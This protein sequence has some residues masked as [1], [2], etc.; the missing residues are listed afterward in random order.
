[1]QKHRLPEEVVTSTKSLW[2]AGLGAA[3]LIAAGYAAWSQFAPQNDPL[4]AYRKKFAAKYRKLT[5]RADQP[6]EAIAYFVN[7]RTGGWVRN[8][9]GR[10]ADR[11]AMAMPL[12][13]SQ[14]L[15]ARQ[16]IRQMNRYSSGTGALL[17]PEANAPA[18]GTLGSWSPL[19]PNNQGG[20]TRKLLIHPTSPNIMYAAAVGGGVWKTTDSGANWLP[21]TD[22]AIPNIAVVSLAF[23]PNNPNKIYAG[24][25]EGYFNADAIRGAGIF[26]TTDAGASWNQLSSTT[27]SDFWYVNDIVVSPRNTNRLYA[28]TR[29]G[30]F[31]SINGGAS[32]TPIATGP[33]GCGD[34]AIQMKRTVGF[35]FASCGMFT[36]TGDVKRILDSDAGATMAQIFTTTNMSRTVLAIAP[37]NE[38]VI[39]ALASNGASGSYNEGVLGVFRSTTNGNAGSWTTQML[40]NGSTVDPVPLNN[41][42]LTNPIF[43]YTAC[44]GPS[45]RGLFN[46]GWYDAV[47]EVDPVDSNRVWAGGI[48]LFRSD[49]GGINFGVASYWWKDIGTPNYNHAD[50]HG[51]AFHPNYD[52]VGNRIMYAVNDGGIFRT[53]NARANVGTT[54][55]NVCG[56][57][58]AGAVTWTE[59]NNGYSTTQFYHGS[60]FPDGNSYL[61][62][63]QDNG[64]WRGSTASLN[65]TKLLG[66]DGGYTAVDEQPLAANNVLFAEFTGLSLQKSTNNGVTFLDAV[67]GITE[68]PGNFAFINPFHMNPGNKQHLWTGGFFLWRTTDQAA[69]WTQ[70]SAITPGDAS[71]SAIAASN[72]DSN[73]VVFGM[74]DGYIGFNT[75]A[76][77]GT[78]STVWSNT[79]PRTVAVTSLAFDP[80]NSNNVWATYSTFSGVS[81]YRSTNS[82]ATWVAVPGTGV[83]SL[84][85]LPAFSVVVDP[86]DSNRVY[87]GT[88]MGVFTTIDGG[89][90][91]YKEV[92]G[93]ANVSTEWL[94]I[95]TSGTRRLTAFTHG[96]GAWR[97][98]LI[99]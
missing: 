72:L 4:Q 29:S 45:L 11:K 39:Y 42:L 88:D 44:V 59:I 38:S 35:V 77:G 66:G 43:A 78:G 53:N 79:R 62:G 82:G 21:L 18:G 24:T 69:N 3:A 33:N 97:T 95:N 52:G 28:A 84:P 55:A 57:T 40:N 85:Q 94:D 32:W 13:T 31:K 25:G 12:D 26:V 83:N 23:D 20:R 64:T 99:P 16:H 81:V 61:G 37:S 30:V 63:F 68:A 49:D 41:L 93:F 96:R 17:A 54:V 70:A 91:W 67:T 60:T 47:L 71:V 90:N 73:K 98:N 36:N 87:V 2:F 50:N 65:W 58:V 1:M 51:I 9:S 6:A 56:T 80:S 92:T 15:R 10:G 89:V 34:L 5:E 74:E 27:S 76:L 75:A 86:A 46:Q 22:L 7:R 48:D 19:G 8:A 14:Y